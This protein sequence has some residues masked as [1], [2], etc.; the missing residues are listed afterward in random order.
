VSSTVRSTL[1]TATGRRRLGQLAGALLAGSLVLSACSGGDSSG[2]ASASSTSVAADATFNTADVMFAQM[3]IPHHQQ[4]IEMAQLTAD[5]STNP[6]VLDLAARIEAAQGPEIE[7]L[8][9][10]LED[11]GQDTASASMGDM[12]MGGDMG[13]MDMGGM[14]SSEDMASLEAASGTEFDRMWLEMMIEHHTGAIGMA[15]TEISDGE[16]QGAVSMAED[17]KSSQNQEINE[18]EQLLQ[19]LPQS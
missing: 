3:M 5:R 18:M 13:G 16:D 12:D 2:S 1:S 17:I 8:T 14:M 4:A 11:W 6:E 7:Q 10:W 9:G 15:E 19:S